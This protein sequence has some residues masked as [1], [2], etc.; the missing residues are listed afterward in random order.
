M[1][2]SVPYGVPIIAGAARQL[3]P[4]SVLD[5]GI[6]FGKYGM[7]FRE[8]LDIWDMECVADYDPAAWKT[9]IDGIEATAIPEEELL[10]SLMGYLQEA[11]VAWDPYDWQG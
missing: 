7:L 9:R 10:A 6:G 2:T 4:K 8:Y 1:P 3:R 11:P 5:V